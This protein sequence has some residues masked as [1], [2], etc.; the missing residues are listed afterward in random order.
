[1]GWNSW[2]AYGFTIDEK[3]F[4]A[5]VDALAALKDYGWQY[6]VIDEGW[7]MRD[8]LGATLAARKYIWD[9]GGNLIPDEGRFPTAAN[10]AGFKPLADYVHGKGLKFGIHIVRGIPRQVVT[11]NLPIN[12]STFHAADAADVK[13]ACP[14]D[15]G[16]WGVLDNAAGQAYYDAMFQ[17]F[18]KWGLDYVKVDCISDHPYRVTEIRQIARA[19]KNSGRPMV[20]SLSPGPTNLSHADEVAELSQLWRIAD[21]HWDGWMMPKG[22]DSE[23]PFGLREEFDRIA[24]WNPHRKPGCYPDPDMLPI[25]FLGPHPGNGESRPS[26]LTRD[27]QRTEITL[28]SIS[29]SPLILGSNMLKLDDFTRSLLTNKDLMLVDQTAAVSAPLTTLPAGFEQARVWKATGVPSAP[30]AAYYALF[31]LSDAPLTLHFRWADLG[32]TGKEAKDL[33]SGATRKTADAVELVLPPH[34]SAAYKVQ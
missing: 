29:R 26:N 28:W 11:E 25:G 23:Y 1:M 32:A 20:L 12:G 9:A 31:N 13:D 33:W 34:A 2:D 16:N 17:L 6:A 22:K 30:K 4:K 19:I 5:S 3:D 21:D 10:G 14:W 15:E 27:E 24:A 7:Y 18:A 8:P